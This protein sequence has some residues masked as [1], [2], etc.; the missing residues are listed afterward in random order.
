MRR[1]P[2]RLA[3]PLSVLLAA[4]PLPAAAPPAGAVELPLPEGA[5]ALLEQSEAPASYDLPVAPFEA[6]AVPVLTFE[7]RVTRRSWRLPGGTASLEVLAPMRAALQAQGFDIILDCAARRCGG[8]RFRFG[9]EVVPAPD[10]Y[11]NLRDFRFLSAIRG[12]DA[13]TGILVSASPTATYVQRI[14]VTALQ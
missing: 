10:M 8:F 14:D 4:A 2:A 1:A 7:G 12:D 6:G 3:L 9:I 5:Q 13:A 11:V